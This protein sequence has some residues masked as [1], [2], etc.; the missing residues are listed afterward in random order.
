MDESTVNILEVSVNTWPWRQHHVSFIFSK[1]TSR[2]SKLESWKSVVA[3]CCVCEDPADTCESKLREDSETV[4]QWN[5]FQ[6]SPLILSQRCSYNHLSIHFVYDTKS[7]LILHSTLW[8]AGGE[9]SE[10]KT[11]PRYQKFMRKW[12]CVG[13]IY[14]LRKHCPA[15]FMVSVTSFM[16]YLMPRKFLLLNYD[17]IL[18]KNHQQRSGQAF[19]VLRFSVRANWKVDLSSVTKEEQKKIPVSCF[20]AF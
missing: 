3:V 1:L 4:R 12:P 15:E 19:S 13:L 14:D 10:C 7:A 20:S 5:Y 16:S 17:L 9:Y 18:H 2:V 11:R 8:P 6:I